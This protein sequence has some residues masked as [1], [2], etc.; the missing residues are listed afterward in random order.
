VNLVSNIGP[1]GT[2]FHGGDAGG[3]GDY[4]HHAATGSWKEEATP[5][6]VSRNIAF[7]L[8][9]M[10]RHFLRHWSPWTKFK[11]LVKYYVGR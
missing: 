9:H 11:K 5:G 1:E 6:N 7:D 2:H 4:A 8:Y 3:F 10:K